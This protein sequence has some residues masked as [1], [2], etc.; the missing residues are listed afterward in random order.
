MCQALA[1]SHRNSLA[2]THA[3]WPR[4]N[5]ITTFAQ[6]TQEMTALGDARATGKLRLEA[7]QGGTVGDQL[8]SEKPNRALR[9]IRSARF[10]WWAVKDSN[11]GPAD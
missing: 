11:L 3:H 2:L 1:T 9:C 8:A 5:D 6:P 7:A 10:D 4:P